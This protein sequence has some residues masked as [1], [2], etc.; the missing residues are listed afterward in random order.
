[1]G[2]GPNRRQWAP[3]GPVSSY[4]ALYIEDPT[5]LSLGSFGVWDQFQVASAMEW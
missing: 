5:P 2:L 1:M 4:E 3:T